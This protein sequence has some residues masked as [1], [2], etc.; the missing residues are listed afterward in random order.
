M[1]QSQ[2]CSRVL[3]QNPALQKAVILLKVSW[4]VMSRFAGGSSTSS[5][6]ER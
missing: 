5:Q 4:L 1:Q 2:S 6:G 3:K